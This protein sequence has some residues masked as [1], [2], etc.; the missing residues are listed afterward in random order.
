MKVPKTDSI[1]ELAEFWDTHDLTDF[2]A[3]LEEVSEP[4]FSRPSS[5]SVTVPL[6]S[7]EREAIRQM[8][9]SR[10]VEEATLIREWVQEKL[11][12]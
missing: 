3:E 10:G 1:R 6:S 7:A 2:S 12:H 9:L 8:A 5:S 11:H 4:V